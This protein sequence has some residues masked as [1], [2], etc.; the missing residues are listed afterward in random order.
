VLS[1]EDVATLQR[2]RDQGLAH[3]DEIAGRYFAQDDQRRVG[4]EY[5]RNN[6]K[7]YLGPDERAGLELFYRYAAEAGVVD[8]VRA[9][10]FY[11]D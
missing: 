5:L 10:R 9:L 3:L 2:A 1:R 8:G 7:Y 11:E 4:A 6:I